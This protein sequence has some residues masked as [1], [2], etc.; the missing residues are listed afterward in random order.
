MWHLIEQLLPLFPFLGM[1]WSPCCCA[2]PT[3]NIIEPRASGTQ[4]STFLDPGGDDHTLNSHWTLE[5]GTVSVVANNLRMTAGNVILTNT[6]PLTN[7]S[8][9]K[10]HLGGFTL[11]TAGDIVRIYFD[12]VDSGGGAL[13]HFIG[14]DVAQYSLIE[15]V[16][17]ANSSQLTLWKWTSASG[18][19]L[20]KLRRK[21]RSY[22]GWGTTVA[23]ALT[24]SLFRGYLLCFGPIPGADDTADMSGIF[25]HPKQNCLSI[26]YS[27]FFGRSQLNSG[28]WAIGGAPAGDYIQV[29]DSNVLAADTVSESAAGANCLPDTCCTSALFEVPSEVDIT[30][31]GNEHT[32]GDPNVAACDCPTDPVGFS[33]LWTPQFSGGNYLTDNCY[34]YE[35][36][37]A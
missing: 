34:F 2:P 21:A 23:S 19:T 24:F 33:A 35:T 1:L 4:F 26:K 18:G 36:A 15:Y 17:A 10:V 37:L 31:T 5:Q 16:S 8:Q 7:L 11:R 30:L 6:L 20:T 32:P 3:C 25:L 28:T 22:V 27:D 9:C 29:D 12:P 13:D 14:G